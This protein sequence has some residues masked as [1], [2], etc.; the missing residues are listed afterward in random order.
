MIKI[1]L[2]AADFD[3]LV[4][5]GILTIKRE[6]IEIK[7]ILQDIGF[8]YMHKIIDEIDEKKTFYLHREKRN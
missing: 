7:M 5:G 8:H 3:C 6:E 2:D 4:S 1:S